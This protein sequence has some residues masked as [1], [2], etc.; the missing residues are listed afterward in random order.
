MTKRDDEGGE[1][2]NLFRTIHR[3]QALY[4]GAS[5][6]VA[7]AVGSLRFT[8][9][10]A[11][12]E[13]QANWRWCNRCQALYFAGASSGPGPCV[14]G[15]LHDAT[16]S[17]N[18]ILGTSSS[19]PGQ[20]NWRWCNRCMCLFYGGDRT[21]GVCVAGGPHSLGGSGEYR[22]VTGPGTPGQHAWRW[23]R[24]CEVLSYTGSSSRIG[25]CAAGGVH[26]TG[27]SGEYS[28]LSIS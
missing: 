27:A 4:L 26:D 22:V 7:A 9:R 17:G 1:S 18:Y 12:S 24:N 20:A 3:R 13:Y 28:L 2:M 21:L 10:A 14:A 16:G 6:L 11:A 15:G 23:C 25:P 19:L 8:A 5:T